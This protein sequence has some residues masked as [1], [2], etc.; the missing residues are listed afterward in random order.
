MTTDTPTVSLPPVSGRWAELIAAFCT[1]LKRDAA[2]VEARLVEEV[3]ARDDAALA[4]LAA[5]PVET[6]VGWLTAEPVKA[7]EAMVRAAVT[8]LKT[9]LNPAEP[10]KAKESAPTAMPTTLRAARLLP[11]LPSE[12]SAL[13]SLVVGGVLRGGI[14][15]AEVVGAVKG[16]MADAIALYDGPAKIVEAIERASETNATPVTDLEGVLALVNDIRRARRLDD[17]DDVTVNSTTASPRNR[18]EAVRRIREIM[19]PAL[20]RHFLQVHAWFTSNQAQGF[21]VNTMLG[22]FGALATGNV[23]GL[24]GLTQVAPVDG[25]IAA[26][27]ELNEAVNLTFAPIYTRPTLKAMAYHALRVA[28]YL[29][30]N[31]PQLAMILANTG[32]N[33]RE[34]LIKAL[35]INVTSAYLR[36]ERALMEYVYAAMAMR[37]VS[38]SDLPLYAT[39]LHQLGLTIPWAQLGQASV[40]VVGTPSLPPEARVT[41]DTPGHRPFLDNDNLDS[42]TGLDVVKRRGAR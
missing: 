4:I 5:T 2:L 42:Q 6:F 39:Q 26:T 16:E 12:A 13:E 8:A 9:A 15:D 36:T 22:A 34:E 40:A 28:G 30:P 1:T 3:E 11:Q 31:G 37:N 38:E 20:G 14:T 27:A 29:D 19:Y 10:A 33:T 17:V 25:L 32:K 7:K 35:N 24:A 18:K 23:A 41:R 21:D